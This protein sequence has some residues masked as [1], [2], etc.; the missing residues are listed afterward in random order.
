MYGVRR[1]NSLPA[2]VRAGV[3][4]SQKADNPIGK[5]NRFEITV[6]K[7]KVTVV[8]NGKTV[9]KEVEIPNFPAKG[10]I[11]LQHHGSKREGQWTSAPALM[12]YRNIFIKELHP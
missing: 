2:Q 1:D 4:P 11:G 12:Q 8:L 9:I 7:G 10:P 6:L 5:W 3:T